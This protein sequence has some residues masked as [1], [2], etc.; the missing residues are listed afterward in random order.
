MNILMLQDTYPPH[1]GGCAQ[2][3]RNMA[4]GLAN[5]GHRVTVLTSGLVGEQPRPGPPVLAQLK[6]TPSRP[7]LV[8]LCGYLHRKQHN[9]RALR[10]TLRE[11]DY[12]IIVV[13]SLWRVSDAVV[14]AARNSGMPLVYY[15]HDGWLIPGRKGRWEQFWGRRAGRVELRVIK[16][17]LRYAGIKRALELLLD[18][19]FGKGPPGP[20]G[21]CAAFVSRSCRKEYLEA[22]FPVDEATIIYNGIDLARFRPP[23]ARPAGKGLRLLYV[24]RIDP[25]KGVHILVEAAANLLQESPNAYHLSLAGPVHDRPY[26][27]RI[28]DIVES[29]G[30]SHTVTF[31]GPL[32]NEDMPQR[33]RDHDVLVFPSVGT[34]RFPLV[35]LEAMAS[36]L[37]VVTTLTGGHDEFLKDGYN[38][39]VC[40]TGDARHLS[41]QLRTLARD[42][43]LRARIAAAGMM[44]VRQNFDLGQNR[45]SMETFLYNSLATAFR[46]TEGQSAPGF[47]NAASTEKS[48]AS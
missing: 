27:K 34:E 16:W 24:G 23:C 5:L 41:E 26:L 30:I 21:A 39:L 6:V 35:I 33:Y 40:R 44:T 20:A 46:H 29:A 10:R 43:G 8:R 13:W 19:W 31:L 17:L 4:E 18:Q 9:L 28:V 38:C 12:D 47:N 22:G 32:E 15:L 42:S 48:T 45:I 37:A 1:V 36:G 2:A 7:I 3:C 14:L 11:T 25:F